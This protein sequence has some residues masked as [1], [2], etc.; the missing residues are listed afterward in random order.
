MDGFKNILTTV[1][2]VISSLSILLII[3]S[4]QPISA[5]AIMG[6]TIPLFYL[7]LK[8]GRKNYE[9]GKNIRK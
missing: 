6:V 5:I 3:F 7:S 1:Y 2:L 9:L 4:I 8:T